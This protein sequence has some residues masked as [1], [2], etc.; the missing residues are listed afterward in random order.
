[1]LIDVDLAREDAEKYAANIGS[2]LG[3]VVFDLL[4]HH[5]I[6]EFIHIQTS[7]IDG[8]NKLLY[9]Y[10]LTPM[11]DKWAFKDEP[12]IDILSFYEIV[13]RGCY[14]YGNGLEIARSDDLL[15]FLRLADVYLR[16]HNMNIGYWALRSDDKL[17]SRA[18]E[19]VSHN[20]ALAVQKIDSRN[21]FTDT[22]YYLYDI[23]KHK[24]HTDQAPTITPRVL[25]TLA[26]VSLAYISQLLSDQK[27]VA[28]KVK[29]NWQI[30]ALSAL[31]WLKLRKDCPEWIMR[32]S[33]D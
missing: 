24:R 1:M 26:D 13:F 3:G 8:F 12:K 2:L 33:S 5:M 14:E 25:A 10:N 4:D 29:G 18:F 7:G 16:L 27:L 30:D 32:L 19:D 15:Y 28:K 22:I 20:Y 21:L 9:G 31:E 6:G 23:P 11:D 17:A